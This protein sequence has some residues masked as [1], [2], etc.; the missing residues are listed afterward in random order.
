MKF[1]VHKAA[2]GGYFDHG[3]LKTYHTFSFADY[4]NPERVHFGALRVLNDDTVAPKKGF[5]MH[6]H[7]N[8]E[9]VS[10]PL[11]G[12]LRH[13]DSVKNEST[14]TPG[15]IQVMSTG[16][17]IYHSEYNASE[18]EELQF[19]Q[20]WIIPNIKETKPEYHNYDIRPLYKH[21][22]LCMFISPKGGNAPA[23]LL[24]D[25]WFSIGTFDSKQCIKY[26][27]NKKNTG[28]YIFVLEG[29]VKINGQ[30][31][32]RRDGIGIWEVENVSIECLSESHILAIEVS[33]I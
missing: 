24:Q 20:I 29:D 10:I 18:T 13:G 32:S 22:E 30:I 21:N 12:F 1:I 6:P 25:A 14:I 15:E 8:M 31:L 33:V 19:L 2:T 11:Q 3:W 26:L 5:G 28:V 27:M 4:Y 17:G 23:H 7:H 9:V 16:A